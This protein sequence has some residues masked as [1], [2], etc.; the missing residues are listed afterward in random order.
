[1]F[2]IRILISVYSPGINNPCVFIPLNKPFVSTDGADLPQEMLH[3][4][5]KNATSVMRS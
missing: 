2:I 3:Y 4:Q 5:H 1:M